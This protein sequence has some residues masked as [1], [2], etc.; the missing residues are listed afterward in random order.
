MGPLVGGLLSLT[1][2]GTNSSLEEDLFGFMV[3]RISV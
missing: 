3:S 1:M 2:P